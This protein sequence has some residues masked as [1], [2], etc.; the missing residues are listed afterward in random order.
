MT[1]YKVELKKT[2]EKN[3][4]KLPKPVIA[5]IIDLLQGLVHE[6]RPADVKN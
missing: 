4:F 1:C 3:L 5:K 2:A 6:P